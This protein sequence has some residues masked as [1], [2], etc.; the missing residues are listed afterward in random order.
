MFKFL[1]W[2]LKTLLCQINYFLNL[3]LWEK[4]E[5][6]K[7]LCFMLAIFLGFRKGRL[8]KVNTFYNLWDLLSFGKEIRKVV[9]FH[10]KMTRQILDPKHKGIRAWEYGLLLSQVDLKKGMNVL[11]LGSGASA[12]PFYLAS[13]G[14]KVTALDL[15]IPLEKPNLQLVS[16]YPNLSYKQGNM[17][18][19]PFRKPLFDLAVCITAIEHLD[20][21]FHEKKPVSYNIFLKRVQRALSEMVR[22]LKPGGRLFLTSD[23]FFPGLQTTDR[24]PQR[25]FYK[26]IGAAFRVE[27]FEDVII[28]NLIKSGCKLVTHAD[29]NFSKVKENINR[30]NFRGRYFTTF[31]LYVQKN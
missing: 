24:Y 21:N 19:L 7:F 27:D 23:V 8:K 28:K 22:V 10:H 12:M 6:F 13:Q 16:K 1:S 18:N 15:D 2:F 29:F 20:Y 4:W 17:L 30:A 9:F 11:D 5:N 26:R 31:A 25:Y 3:S 14:I